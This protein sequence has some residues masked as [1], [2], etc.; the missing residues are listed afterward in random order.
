[1]SVFV[2][3]KHCVY[4]DLQE[5][6]IFLSKLLLPQIFEKLAMQDLRALIADPE[7]SRMTIFI[8]GETI[9]IPHHSVALLL[10]GYLKTQGRQELVTAPAALLPSPGNLSFQNL[11][12]SG[13]LSQVKAVC[14]IFSVKYFLLEFPLD[15]RSVNKEI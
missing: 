1:L 7:R 13:I 15:K 3:I 2:I 5:S 4:L 12:G 14:K 6:A 10:E 9:E 8:R 11:A